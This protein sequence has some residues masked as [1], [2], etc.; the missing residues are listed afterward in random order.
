[1]L[2][3]FLDWYLASSTIEGLQAT[4]PTRWKPICRRFPC[5]FQKEVLKGHLNTVQCHLDQKNRYCKPN[6]ILHGVKKK[7]LTTDGFILGSRMAQQS[8]EE[9]GQILIQCVQNPQ[10]YRGEDSIYSPHRPLCYQ[11]YQ[12]QRLQIK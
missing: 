5:E 4:V 6:R 7:Q 9:P 11:Y 12:R 2:P 10:G 1:V 3:P 8:D